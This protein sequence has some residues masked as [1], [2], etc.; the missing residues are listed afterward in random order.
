[1]T[2]L[3]IILSILFLLFLILYVKLNAFLALIIT[4]LLTGMM[5]QMPITNILTS[6]EKGIGGTLGQ[7]AL[8]L[9]FGA[10]LGAILAE[11]GAIQCIST[12]L[13]RVFTPKYIQWAILL[14]SFMV[15]IPMFFNAAFIILIPIIYHLSKQTRLPLMYLG[16]PMVA[17]L[18]VTHGYLPPHLAPTAICI[19]YKAHISLVLAYGLLI[20]L[21]AAIT[22]GIFTG[23]Y[24]KKIQVSIPPFFETKVVDN[25]KLPPLSISVFITLSPLIF[26][27][28]GHL[29]SFFTQSSPFLKGNNVLFSISNLLIDPSVSLLFSLLLAII[30]LGLRQ[31]QTMPKLMDLVGQSVQPIA[32]ILL[33][34]AGGGA[35]KQVLIDSNAGKEIANALLGLPVSPLILAWA[36]TATLRICLGSSTVAAMTAVGL[37]AP[38]ADSSGVN[39]ELLT[40]ATGAGSI[41]FSNVNDTGFWLF[42]SYFGTTIGQ[43]FRSWSVMEAIVSLVG[44][45]GV[46][47]L[48][49]FV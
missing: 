35:F 32:L 8:I 27:G 34:I 37:I 21:P 39:R 6:I 30:L 19:A 10:M 17:A 42:K 20:G 14:T 31:G 46:L 11:S 23:R 36:I 24:M 40:L 26:I 18:S 43:T 33:I 13:I 28:F 15:G 16:I 9:S 29:L 48:N 44:L 25:I 3:I 45:A 2:I 38:L 7:L 49:N 12:Y 5:L 1:M 22:G 47:L 4:S 41:F